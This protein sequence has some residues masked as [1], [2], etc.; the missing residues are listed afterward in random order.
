M[1][2]FSSGHSINMFILARLPTIFK[3]TTPSTSPI[4]FL[5][6]LDDFDR[7]DL[8]SSMLNQLFELTRPFSDRKKEL[9]VDLCPSNHHEY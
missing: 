4:S 1:H 5:S 2:I 9:A 3:L 7:P 6:V 8:V